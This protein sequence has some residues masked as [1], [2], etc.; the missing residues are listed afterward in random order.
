MGLVK[1]KIAPNGLTTNYEYDNIENITNKFNS[2]GT[3]STVKTTDYNYKANT[4]TAVN[5]NGKKLK[6]TYYQAGDSNACAY[7]TSVQQ[8]VLGRTVPETNRQG[9]V[10]LPY[11]SK[12]GFTT[13]YNTSTRVAK[14]WIETSTFR[15]E[16]IEIKE[17]GIL[18]FKNKKYYS[19]KGLLEK[20]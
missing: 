17:N 15:S 16:S 14:D 4:I 5:E 2:G 18:W 7:T 6:F 8:D 20:I 1:E 19:M 13:Q 10:T 12:K 3:I 9:V 11:G